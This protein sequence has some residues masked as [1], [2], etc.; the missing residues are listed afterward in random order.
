MKVVRVTKRHPGK[1][2][3]AITDGEH[4]FTVLRVDGS[5][6]VKGYPP[7]KL[8][9]ERNF[10]QSNVVAYNT[11]TD[12]AGKVWSGYFQDGDTAT[13][14]DKWGAAT[15]D[16]ANNTFVL[17]FTIDEQTGTWG[18]KP[19]PISVIKQSDDVENVAG[20]LHQALYVT[21][22]ASNVDN[23]GGLPFTVEE[24]GGMILPWDGLS[25]TITDQGDTAVWL[26]RTATPD[27]INNGTIDAPKWGW[28]NTHSFHDGADL[29]PYDPTVVPLFQTYDTEA[30]ADGHSDTIGYG[31]YAY[32]W[33]MVLFYYSGR[34]YCFARGYIIDKAD[35]PLDVLDYQ[36]YPC[37]MLWACNVGADPLNPASWA[38]CLDVWAAYDVDNTYSELNGQSATTVHTNFIVSGLEYGG[39]YFFYA[40]PIVPLGDV[41]TDD[42]LATNEVAVRVLDGTGLNPSLNFSEK[43]SYGGPLC[44]DGTNLYWPEISVSEQHLYIWRLDDA[45]DHWTLAY[46]TA[47]AI[48]EDDDHTR[49]FITASYCANGRV[50]VLYGQR[51][52]VMNDAPIPTTDG[53]G[54]R[55]SMATVRLATGL[56]TFLSPVMPVQDFYTNGD[57]GLFARF[58]PTL[59][60]IPDLGGVIGSGPCDETFAVHSAPTITE[61][62][63]QALLEYFDSPLLDENTATYFYDLIVGYG[64]DPNFAAAIMRKESIFGSVPGEVL[65]A[66]KN[67]FNLRPHSWGRQT[68][69]IS[70]SCCGLFSTYSSYSDAVEDFCELMGFPIYSGKPISEV[71]SIFAPPSDHNNTELYI[72]QACSRMEAWAADE[73]PGP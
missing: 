43:N 27:K 63:F 1:A 12:D 20:V 28:G 55:W 51:P 33:P 15:W 48:D 24:A 2:A 72:T 61:T 35:D 4:V 37:F 25:T 71:I 53:E 18:H 7:D 8:L 73:V 34:F 66:S 3:L 41:A 19:K 10:R 29:V 40:N 11:F 16:Q 47:L 60:D 32:G 38:R 68:G 54:R 65:L 26:L 31:H 62:T 22:Q 59:P 30:G 17:Q 13:H 49:G 39:K 45:P 50:Y 14:V 69:T 46:S 36:P 58:V 64:V 5:K 23:S 6:R 56:W 44:T 21:A 52:S 67:P 70:T 9:P 57:N 42:A